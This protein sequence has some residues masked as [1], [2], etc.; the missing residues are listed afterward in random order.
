MRHTYG[1]QI[2][3]I[4]EMMHLLIHPKQQEPKPTALNPQYLYDCL[5]DAAGTIMAKNITKDLPSVCEIRNAEHSWV[6]MVDGQEFNFIG[7][8]FA[9]YFKKHYTSLGYVVQFIDQE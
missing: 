1:E 8:D 7:S 2:N 6:L 5:N 4:K 3:A 9:E